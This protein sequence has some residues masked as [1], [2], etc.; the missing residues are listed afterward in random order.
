MNLRAVFLIIGHLLVIFALIMLIPTVIALYHCRWA[1]GTEL[2]AFAV[3]LLSALATGFIMKILCRK[4]PVNELTIREGFAT[5]T[6]GWVILTFFGSLPFYLSGS[7]PSLIDAYFETMSGLTTTGATVIADVEKLPRGILFWRSLLH[8]IGGMGIV[9]LSVAILPVMGAGGYQLFRAEVPGPTHD[10]LTP[11]IAETAKKLWLVYLVLS[12]LNV[13][14]LLLGGMPL[15]DSLCH[16]FGT[17]ATGGFSTKNASIGHYNSAYFDGVITVFM[18]LAGCNL[19]LHYHLLFRRDWRPFYQNQELRCFVAIVLVATV[20]VTGMLY[21]YG[22][23]GRMRPGADQDHAYNTILGAFRY[24][25]FQVVSIITT[26]GYC[27][28]NFDIWPEPCRYILLFLMFVG[29]CAGSTAGGIKV[30][31]V[32]VLGKAALREIYQ[33]INPREIVQVKIAGQTIPHQSILTILIFFIIYIGLFAFFTLAMSVLASPAHS[34]GTYNLVTSF[35]SVAATL[36]NIGPGLAKVGAYENFAWMPPAGKF[37]MILCMLIGRLE[38]YSVIVLLS[39]S[40][41]R[42]Y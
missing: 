16:T 35:S 36:G 21:S 42:R 33:L 10:R 23:D 12:A 14:F 22:N 30:F 27:T 28:A 6:L 8:W 19:V 40:L 17:M 25:V 29:G 38:I 3:S 4:S 34:D 26:T 9:A 15:Y 41:W 37:I 7:C 24:G 13:I 20:L 32:M 1:E 31:R 5:V 39:P 2:W 11:R 18:F